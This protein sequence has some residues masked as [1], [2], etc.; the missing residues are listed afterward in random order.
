MSKSTDLD[1]PA[2]RATELTYGPVDTAR[3]PA[4]LAANVLGYPTQPATSLSP[5]CHID[6]F[7]N[8]AVPGP[9][10]TAQFSPRL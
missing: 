5:V 10:Y 8:P 9:V 3:I 7:D 1:L 2:S 6:F 4:R